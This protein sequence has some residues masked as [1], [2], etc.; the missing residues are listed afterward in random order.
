MNT[1]STSAPLEPSAPPDLTL[2]VHVQSRDNHEIF[3]FDILCE[4]LHKRL[5]PFLPSTIIEQSQKKSVQDFLNQISRISPENP[6]ASKELAGIGINLY[7]M[8]FPD[9]LKSLYWSELRK[10][11]KSIQIVSDEN[12]LPWQLIKPVRKMGDGIVEDKYWGEKYIVSRWPSRILNQPPIT[13]FS[14]FNIIIARDLANS[15]LP[16]ASQELEYIQKVLREV[17][18]E[19]RVTPAQSKDFY[20][21]LEAGGFAVLHITAHANYDPATESCEIELEDTSIPDMAISGDRTGFARECS[22]VFIN[23]CGIARQSGYGLSGAGGFVRRLLEPGVKA[24]LCTSWDVS[25]EKA[26][27]FS[28]KFY[29]LLLAGK[30]IGESVQKARLHIKNDYDPSWLSYTFFGDPFAVLHKPSEAG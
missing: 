4:K 5:Y 29:D 28:K 18:I 25:D 20:R 21:V 30:P 9:E 3:N 1:K 15:N 13:T 7:N 8:L 11:V 19:I 23:A 26:M 24:V 12:W 14:P 17:G 6:V 22:F 16:H 10:H 27:K 2:R